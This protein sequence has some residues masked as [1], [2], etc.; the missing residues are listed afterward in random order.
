M[1]GAAP[2]DPL[3]GTDSGSDAD[4]GDSEGEY[5]GDAEEPQPERDAGIQ[6]SPADN[7]RSQGS[8]AAS[9]SASPEPPSRPDDEP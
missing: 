5:D 7:N 6:A 1:G 2:G 3:S 8:T 4:A 9:D